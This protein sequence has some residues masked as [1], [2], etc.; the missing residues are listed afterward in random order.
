MRWT[1]GV[2]A[3]HPGPWNSSAAAVLSYDIPHTAPWDFRVSLYTWTKSIAAGVYLVPLLLLMTGALDPAG[4]LWTRGRACPGRCLPGPHRR[5]PDLGPGTPHALPPHL[6]ASPVAKLAGAGRLHHRRLRGCSGRPLRGH[7]DRR[8]PTTPGS[9]GSEAASRSSRPSTPPSSSG[10]P[11]RATCGRTRCCR[12]T[13]SSRPGSLEGGVTTLAALALRAPA[14][15]TEAAP[16]GLRS[17]QRG[18][19]PS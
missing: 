18:P 13:S 19:T 1:T 12:R 14:A 8:L 6:P 17:L 11:R 9:A 16:A 3:G 5:H 15:V 7:P 10:R 2:P 4:T